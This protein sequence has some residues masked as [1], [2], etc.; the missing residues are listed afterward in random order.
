MS[1]EAVDPL[2]RA[3]ECGYLMMKE[4]QHS[5]LNRFEEW[6][7]EHQL[8]CV[9]VARKTTTA[10]VEMH[11]AYLPERLTDWEEQKRD[12]FIEKILDVCE[13]AAG[14]YTT[15]PALP[16]T[17][18]TLR[19]VP[20]ENAETLAQAFL[21]IVRQMQ[22][23]DV[24]LP[25]FEHPHPFGEVRRR[26]EEA[27]ERGYARAKGVADELPLRYE[28][29]AKVHQQSFLCVWERRAGYAELQAR[30]FP[31]LSGTQVRQL[32]QALTPLGFQ[33]HPSKTRDSYNA[34]L[35]ATHLQM[36]K[37]IPIDIASSAA[38]IIHDFLQP[39]LESDTSR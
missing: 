32:C 18:S 31:V 8:P 33:S 12:T 4:G 30:F 29:W 22:G 23:M 6:C 38:Q 20:L 36:T 27:K 3:K 9:W 7:H 10:T 11:Q 17:H 25:V 26:L 34:H 13:Q 28:R 39:E 37:W 21:A 19:R 15:W 1:V 2:T 14:T 5:L 35:E 16:G 24:P